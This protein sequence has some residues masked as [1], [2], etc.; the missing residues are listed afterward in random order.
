MEAVTKPVKKTAYSIVY[1]QKDITASIASM[2]QSVRYIDKLEGHSD[3]VEITVD[4]SLGRWRGAWFPQKGDVVTV[5]LGNAGEKLLPCGDFQVDEPTLKG[6]PHQVIIKGLAAGRTHETRSERYKAYEGQSLRQVAQQVAGRHGYTLVG[7]GG[8]DLVFERLTQHRETDLAFLKRLGEAYGFAFS[9]RG[10][11]LVF[12][13]LAQ[14]DAAASVLTVHSSDLN[15]Y[16]LKTNAN[17]S[18]RG[19]RVQYFN[20]KTGQLASHTEYAPGV[21]KGDI[22][23]LDTRAENPKQARTLAKSALHRHYGRRIEGY[24]DLDGDPRLVT[25]NNI[26]LADMGNLNA[27]YRIRQ[28]THTVD[29]GGVWTVEAEVRCVPTEIRLRD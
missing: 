15:S 9:V 3:E 18:Y 19:V 24:L 7:T 28:S 1:A 17:G 5:K 23:T 4:D 14:L 16:S 29:D 13:D 20:P 22:L 11:K 12:H 10:N 21:L 6:G 8:D 27:L 25:G 26:Q 2:V